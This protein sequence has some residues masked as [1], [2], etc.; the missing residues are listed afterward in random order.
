MISMSSLRLVSN[1][2]QKSGLIHCVVMK[3]RW[4]VLERCVGSMVPVF[5]EQMSPM[6]RPVAAAPNLCRDVIRA[7][8]ARHPHHDGRRGLNH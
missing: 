6:D 3:Y 5:I 8:A 1:V 7:C 2:V 4:E